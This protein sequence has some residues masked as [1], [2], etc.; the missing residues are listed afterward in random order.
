MLF[1]ACWGLGRRLGVGCS[2]LKFQEWS[3]GL[4]LMAAHAHLPA[5]YSCASCVIV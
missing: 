5:L 2:W 3:G 4:L 1:G